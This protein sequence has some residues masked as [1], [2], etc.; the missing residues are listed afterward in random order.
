MAEIFRYR[1]RLLM[2]YWLYINTFRPR[3]DGRYFTDDV[4]K[5]IFFNENVW[6][7]LKIPM[8][9]VPKGPINNIP[10]LVLIIAWRRPGDKPLSE[11]MLVSVPTHIWVTRPQWVKTCEASQMGYYLV[12]S[13]PG[14]RSDGHQEHSLLQD[15][16]NFHRSHPWQID[17]IS[18]T[19]STWCLFVL[20]WPLANLHHHSVDTIHNRIIT[21]SNVPVKP[22]TWALL[23]HLAPSRWG[24]FGPTCFQP[25]DH[26]DG[27]E[28]GGATEWL[29][30]SDMKACLMES[31]GWQGMLHQPWACNGPISHIPQCIGQISHNAP[32]CNRNVHI[33]AHFCYKMV[34]CGIWDWCVHHGINDEFGLYYPRI[35]N[36]VHALW[37]LVVVWYHW[38]T[39][40]LPSYRWYV[41]MHF[42]ML[43]KNFHCHH[44]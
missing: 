27:W 29:A 43:D 26:I 35:R 5:C 4:L 18:N 14:E 44:W 20:K 30:S 25:A 23:A 15:R 22:I 39:K 2:V 12:S 7:S 32:F 41:W 37:C 10:A 36:T 11:P 40:W 42:L 33:Y 16:A 28:K 31:W 38:W 21:S 13:R 6:I 19:A 8:K 34:H 24:Q 9:F 1:L 17:L 3:Q